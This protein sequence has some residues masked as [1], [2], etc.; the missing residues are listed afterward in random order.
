[1]KA[2]P[3]SFC[4]FS[5]EDVKTWL[6]EG[7]IRCDCAEVQECKKEYHP[8]AITHNPGVIYIQYSGWSINL[9]EDG[10]YTVEVTEGG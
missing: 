4:G 10:S 5:F 9:Y 6:R 3:Y 2:K 1:M 8:I 7:R